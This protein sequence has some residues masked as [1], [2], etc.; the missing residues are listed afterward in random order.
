MTTI[1]R[2]TGLEDR[3]SGDW[4]VDRPVSRPTP[5]CEQ[6]CATF[7]LELVDLEPNQRGGFGNA[8]TKL[9][10]GL[11]LTQNLCRL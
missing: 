4:G 1:W 11:L 6:Q 8:Q 7:G 2:E 9:A 3:V 5:R 10:G